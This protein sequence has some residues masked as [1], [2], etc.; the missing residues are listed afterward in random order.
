MRVLRQSIT[1]FTDAMSL[2]FALFLCCALFIP[3]AAIGN[4][5][6]AATAR[7][8]GLETEIGLKGYQFN[9]ALTIFYV[10]YSELASQFSPMARC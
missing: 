5:R 10:F 1:L 4:A 8:P 6:V 2:C 3:T 7:A 9:Y